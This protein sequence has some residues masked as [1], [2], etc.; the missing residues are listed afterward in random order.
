MSGSLEA[1]AF[2]P[3]DRI[4]ADVDLVVT[5]AELG[6]LMFA[7]GAGVPCL[8][9]P[10]VRD[11]DDNAARVTALGLGRA[12]PP[13]AAPAEIGAAVMSML[14][15]EALRATC[16]GFAAR[17]DRFGDLARAATLNEACAGGV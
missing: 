16:R 10:N 15:D 1:R 9:L 6:T 4:V 13:D 11:Q 8:C 5:H 7:A 3:H 14:D 12:L 17:V 2:V